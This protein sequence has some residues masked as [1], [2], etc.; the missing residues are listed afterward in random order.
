MRSANPSIR[1]CS[2]KNLLAL[3]EEEVP[4]VME[5]LQNYPLRLIDQANKRTL[6]FYKFEPYIHAMWVQ[7]QPPLNTG[8]VISRYHEVDDRTRPLSSG[9]NLQLF[10][11]LYSV[12][13]TLFHEYQHFSGDPNE[14]SVFLKTQVFSISFYKRHTAA[15]AGRDAVFA[16]LSELLGLPPAA[17]KCRELN[18]LIEQYYGKETTPAEAMEHAERELNRLNNGIYNV[19]QTQTWD[20]SVKFPLLIENE[21]KE[22][23]DLI[24]NIIIRWDKTP[25][26]ITEKKFREIT[27]K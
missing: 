14:A 1:Y 2:T 19:N 18:S 22:N 8:K 10:R 24:R 12:I 5:M 3:A 27:E 21:D 17:N 7:Y 11:D 15:K 16:R 6:G 25:K 20:P 13:P 9:L 23:R 4:G 26:S